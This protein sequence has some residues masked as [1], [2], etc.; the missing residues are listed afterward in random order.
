MNDSSK[1]EVEEEDEGDEVGSR[2]SGASIRCDGES[3]IR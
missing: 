1:E 2:T 3:V